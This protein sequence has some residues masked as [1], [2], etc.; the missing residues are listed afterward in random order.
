MNKLNCVQVGCGGGDTHLEQVIYVHK[1]NL[2]AF[3]DPDE[4]RHG[5]V[6]T[7]LKGKAL[8]WEKFGR[9]RITG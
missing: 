1:Q 9:S 4:K 2:A 7:Y 3:V 6:P 8:T 5:H